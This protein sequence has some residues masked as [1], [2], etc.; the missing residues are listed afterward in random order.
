MHD[1]LPRRVRALAPFA[2]ALLC[3]AAPLGAQTRAGPKSARPADSALVGMPTVAREFRGVWVATV[4]NID[5]PSR[6]GLSTQEQQAE[7]LELLDRAAAM[8]LNAVIFQVRPAADALY[9]SRLEPW[10]EYLTGVQGQAP[11]PFWDPLRF[12]VQEAHARGLELHAWFNPYRARVGSAKPDTA[13][14][15]ISRTH[16]ELVRQYGSYLWLDPGEPKVRE[17]S[18]RVVM[19]VVRRY[20]VDGIHIDDYFYPYRERAPGG[21]ELDFPDDRSY[22]RYRK[23]G[24]RLAR[25]DWRR[26]NVDL[27]VHGVYT[28]IKAAK[29]WVKFGISPFGIWRSGQPAS[30]TGLDAYSELYADSRK[31]VREGWLDYNTPQLYRELA[32]GHTAQLRWWAEQNVKGRHLWPGNYTSKVGEGGTSGW[33]AAELLEQIRLTRADPGASGN[34]HFSMKAFLNDQEGIATLLATTTYAE[35]ALVPASPWLDRVA[36]AKPIASAHPDSARGG[37]T[38]ALSLAPGGKE[39][40]PWLWTVRAR[41]GDEWRT[42]IVP[43]DVRRHPVAP[44]GVQAMPEEIVVTAVDRVG[45]MSAARVIHVAR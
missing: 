33:H 5:W 28:Q 30:V 21:G 15:H 2:A 31:W 24:G 6:P 36:P 4:G 43:G 8:H 16:P 42:E 44:L 13:R 9:A 12:A 26:H 23:A 32:R 7:L 19:D 11:V 45:N 22:A 35:P 38:L 37:L 40:R 18:T 25:D 17:W 34:V 41:F 14:N 10:S 29:P 3:A 1:F 20:D 27:F 39:S